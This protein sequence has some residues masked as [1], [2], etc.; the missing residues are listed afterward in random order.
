MSGPIR[1]TRADA[2]AG[3]ARLRRALVAA[4]RKELA[5]RPNLGPAERE[6]AV[7]QVTQRVVKRLQGARPR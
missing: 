1:I 3:G 4:I 2:A 5:T 6:E 7:L